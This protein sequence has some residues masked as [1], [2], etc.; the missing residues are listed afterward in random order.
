MMAWKI[1]FPWEKLEPGQ[2]FFVPCLDTTRVLE[3]GL[4]AATGLRFKVTATPGIRGGRLGVWFS[5]L[6]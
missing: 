5:R 3:A 1:V 2:G 4:R 6:P